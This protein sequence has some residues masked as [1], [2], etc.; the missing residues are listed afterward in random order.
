[1]DT[2]NKLHWENIYQTKDTTKVSWYQ[3][4]P[5]VSIDLIKDISLP[6]DVSIIDIGGGDS[7]FVDELLK[8]GYEDITVLDIS[9]TSLEHAKI[10]LGEKSQHIN[11][12]ASDILDFN[13]NKKFDLWHD[14][15]AFHFLNDKIEIE[16]YVQKVTNYLKP[17]GYLILG[18]FS[19]DGPLKCSGLNIH[20]YSEEEMTSVFKTN[21]TKLKCIKKD[22]ITPNNSNQNF[23]FCIFQKME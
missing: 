15:A 14:R 23:L 3:E 19:E 20:R 11:W 4:N 10:R 13:T 21:F 2:E 18:T 16:T 1:M 6:T 8:L 22:H 9:E 12:E 7:L 5:E 17:N